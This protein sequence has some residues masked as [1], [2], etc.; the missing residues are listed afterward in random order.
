MTADGHKVS[1]LHAAFQGRTARRTSRQIPQP[2]E[3]GLHHYKTSWPVALTNV[4]IVINY[5][6][7][8]KGRSDDDPDHETYLHRIGRTGRV[9]I[10]FVSDKKSYQGLN[11]IATHY[12]CH[13]EEPHASELS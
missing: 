7:P 2:R 9:S 10:S 12:G 11:K 5:D 6:I 13:R 4:S 1:A 3:Q 8:M